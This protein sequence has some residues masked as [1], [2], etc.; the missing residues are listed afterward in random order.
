MAYNHFSH[1]QSLL[2]LL[3]KQL[4][5]SHPTHFL[6][7]SQSPHSHSLK[8]SQWDSGN[9]EVP[10]FLSWHCIQQTKEQRLGQSCAE[11]E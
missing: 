2:H 5:Y 10:A 11:N 8:V 4:K 7:P 3:D 6:S 1:L 9:S